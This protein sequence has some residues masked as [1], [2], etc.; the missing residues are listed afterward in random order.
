MSMSWKSSRTCTGTVSVLL[1]SGR[2]DEHCTRGNVGQIE[3]LFA[4]P[5]VVNRVRGYCRRRS[6]RYRLSPHS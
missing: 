1:K 2:L 4:V 5:G 6:I 3:S